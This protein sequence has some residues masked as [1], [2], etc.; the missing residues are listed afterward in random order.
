MKHIRAIKSIYTKLTL[1][2]VLAVVISLTFFGIVLYASVTAADSYYDSASVTNK[3]ELKYAR[4]LQRYVK[5]NNLKSTDTKAINRWVDQHS[6]LSM[7]MTKKGEVVYNSD[8]NQYD[9]D[10][11]GSADTSRRNRPLYI[12]FADGKTEVFFEGI[13]SYSV[14]FML[15]ILSVTLTAVLFL[16]I[17]L[18]GVRRKMRRIRD[19]EQEVKVLRSGNLDHEIL[20]RGDDEIE[21]L[22]REIN[23]MRKALRTQMQQ[24]LKARQN[25]QELVTE[26]SHDL[27]TPLTS[28][29]LYSDMIQNGRC[30][31]REQMMQYVDR[32]SVKANQLKGLTDE[33]FEYA[34]IGQS[35][36]VELQTAGFRDVFF[37]PL[38]VVISYLS[39]AGY[40]CE[41]E[42]EWTD[43]PVY[44]Y[45]DYVPR[46]FDNVVSNVQ[47]YA[48]KSNPIRIRTKFD[49]H[50]SSICF[51]N[52]TN[53]EKYRRDRHRVG[54]KNVRKM[55]EAM[56]G[57]CEVDAE[58]AETFTVTLRFRNA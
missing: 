5:K 51:Q 1:L 56:N 18:L 25:S 45:P 38:S 12:T 49:D 19:L 57:L 6:M 43:R 10:Y 39:E 42:P 7:W 41:G 11:S 4:S 34:L 52:R 33:L 24:E 27:R 2:L 53:P 17:V 44:F 35:S 26:L 22:A 9:E 23:N 50:Y 58:D 48:D 40:R 37:D 13:F 16:T 21:E 20:A 15:I 32:I 14:Y 29:L 54:L 46:I 8:T 55:M 36:A 3:M 47:K 30:E 28:I 31:S